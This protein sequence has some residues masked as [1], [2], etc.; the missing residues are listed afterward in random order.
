MSLKA[1]Q[2]KR[3]GV[4]KQVTGPAS[5]GILKAAIAADPKSKEWLKNYLAK[6]YGVKF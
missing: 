3:L 6:K 4:Y 5:E 1:Q 2:K